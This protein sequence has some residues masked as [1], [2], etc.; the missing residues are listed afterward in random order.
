[1]IERP[2]LITR[3]WAEW[4]EVFAVNAPAAAGA[5]K[6][7]C[8]RRLVNEPGQCAE[9][10]IS[11][12]PDLRSRPKAQFAGCLGRQTCQ[13]LRG[14][15]IAGDGQIAIRSDPQPEAAV[16]LTRNACPTPGDLEF[17]GLRVAIAHNRA[18]S[19]RSRCDEFDRAVSHQGHWLCQGH[20]AAVDELQRAARHCDG[21]SAQLGF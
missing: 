8:G 1:M 14:A 7:A 12:C 21:A 13:S 5:G 20:C 10:N 6:H 4:V 18:R 9:A 11:R 3:C 19:G 17:L 2:R 15:Q 16:D